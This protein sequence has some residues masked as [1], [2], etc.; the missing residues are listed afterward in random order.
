ME[1]HSCINYLLT[2]AQHN[3][4]Q[5]MS[6]RL[7]PYDIT[8]GQYGILNCLWRKETM[9]PKDMAQI[10][11][12]ETSTISGVLDRMQKKGLI[13]RVISPEDRRCVQVIL[14]QKGIA[15]EK[16]VLDAVA[17]VNQIVLSRF[18]QADAETLIDCLRVISQTDFQ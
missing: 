6:A 12:L 2:T 10:L 7:L 11:G 9:N 1:L 5:L 13:D 16:P 8:P 17:E 14:T 18:P 3:V 4:F 15:L